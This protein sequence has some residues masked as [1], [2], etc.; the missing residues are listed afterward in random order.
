MENIVFKGWFNKWHQLAGVYWRNK[1]NR[2]VK[3]PKDL[4]LVNTNYTLLL[5]IIMLE[6]YATYPLCH[7]LDSY[8]MPEQ[9]VYYLSGNDIEK[10]IMV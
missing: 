4:N 1:K 5:Q 7:N 10:I 8:T 2:L 3:K 6:M 9:I